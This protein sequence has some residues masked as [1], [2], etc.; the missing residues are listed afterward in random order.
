M[1]DKEEVIRLFDER[2]IA[3]LAH[4][5]RTINDAEILEDLLN[6]SIQIHFRN[7]PGG[8]TRYGDNGEVGGVWLCR[9]NNPDPYHADITFCPKG[10]AY[11][12]LRYVQAV[13]GIVSLKDKTYAINPNSGYDVPDLHSDVDKVMQMIGLKKTKKFERTFH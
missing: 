9:F 11:E 6:N 4:A 8:E 12:K 7:L 10:K 3:C 2:A 5:A 13:I 1:G